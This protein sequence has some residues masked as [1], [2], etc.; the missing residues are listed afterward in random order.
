MAG[1][2]PGPLEQEWLAAGLLVGSI[3]GLPR[4]SL[5]TR[6]GLVPYALVPA[7]AAAERREEIFAWLILELDRRRGGWPDVLAR[8]RSSRP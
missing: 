4:P 8:L 3:P 5:L 7:E 1:S 2:A 6:Q